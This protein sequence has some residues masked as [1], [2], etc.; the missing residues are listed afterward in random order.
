M[1]FYPK[2]SNLEASFIS[3]GIGEYYDIQNLKVNEI[4]RE[5]EGTIEYHDKHSYYYNYLIVNVTI[6]SYYKEL[7]KLGFKLVKRFVNVNTGNT[8]YFCILNVADYKRKM[9]NDKK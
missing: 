3:C 2:W 5:L 1:T 4:K 9:R 6:E 8:N 7:R